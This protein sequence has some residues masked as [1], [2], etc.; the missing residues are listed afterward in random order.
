MHLASNLRSNHLKGG[1]VVWINRSA[2]AHIIVMIILFVMEG[3]W[4]CEQGKLVAQTNLVHFC[5]YALRFPNY[6]DKTS[7]SFSF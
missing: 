5:L 6:N 3:F 2:S 7:L 1:F 4:L